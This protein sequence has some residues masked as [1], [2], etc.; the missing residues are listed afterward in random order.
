MGVIGRNG[1]GKSTLLKIISRITAPT[2]GS[3]EI[4]G[5]VSSLLEVGTG[6]HPEL[7]GRENIYLNAA[8]LGMKRSEISRKFD[9]IVD[10][11]EVEKFID[12]PVKHYSSGMHVRLAFAVAAHLDSEI[13]LVDEV[14][15]VGD[16]AFQKKC[17][18]KMGEVAK[19]GR[20]ALFVSHNLFAVQNLCQRG[21]L[22]DAGR[23]AYEGDTT[24]TLSRYLDS[25]QRERGEVSWGSPETAPGDERGR[26]KAVRIISNGSVS[27]QVD[28]S[29]PFTIEVDYWNLKPNRK[30]MVSIHLYNEMGVCVMTVGNTPST[31]VEPDAWFSRPYP[32]GLFR[33]SCT[34]PENFLNDGFYFITV[35]VNENNLPNLHSADNIVLARNVLSFEVRDTGEM[36]KEYFG[37]W[38]GVVRPRLEWRT[39]QLDTTGLS[40]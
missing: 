22:M 28:I 39:T 2:E 13:L 37:K 24:T 30:R 25:G 8:I 4:R 19:R 3:V 20:T 21:I 35:Y 34:I 29:K 33:T 9:E 12:T 5:R 14:L 16:T 32:C 15:A 18:G 31:S 10:F 23:I 6:F 27:A 17:I 26:L 7:T 40:Q 36:R 11:A 38:W 1:A